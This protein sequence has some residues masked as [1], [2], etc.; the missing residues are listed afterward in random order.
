MIEAWSN[1]VP[2][3]IN[4]VCFNALT[5]GYAM[6]LKEIDRSV[7]QEV[8]TDLKLDQLILNRRDSGEPIESALPVSRSASFQPSHGRPTGSSNSEHGSGLAA[9]GCRR[10]D[11]SHR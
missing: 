10:L 9:P 2:R 6:G 11:D 1:G 8:L 3:N 5:L 4:S 7:V